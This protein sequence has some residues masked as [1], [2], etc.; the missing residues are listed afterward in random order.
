MAA[1]SGPLVVIFHQSPR[2]G[3]PPFTALLATARDRLVA[4]HTRHFMRAGAARVQVIP[5]RHDRDADAGGFGRR[6]ATLVAEERP[7]HGLIILGSGAVPLL[8]RSDAE[9]LVVAARRGR[10]YA[11]T[12]NRYSSD[13]CAVSQ[14]GAL[15][16][17]L[18]GP[19]MPSDNGLPRWLEADAGYHLQQLPGRRRL[20]MDLDTPLDLALLGL[21]RRAPKALRDLAREL[22]IPGHSALRELASDPRRELLVMGRTNARTLRWLER[23]T[24][25]RVRALI[26]ERGLKASTSGA[27]ARP[28]R[29]VLGRLLT[30]HGPESLA[31]IVG[32][33]S[34]GA[35]IDTRVLLADRLGADEASWPS[36]EDRF[37]SDLGRSDEIHDPWLAALTRSAARAPVPIMLAAHTLVGPGIRVLLGA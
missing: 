3:E 12:N 28:P 17:L 34:D 1:M 15:L 4:H 8:R 16:A 14:P 9:R 24:R 33:L 29:S 21:V 32:E 35:I 5:G 10:R 37:A 7:R 27:N 19:P 18:D 22:P 31:D 6:L 36:P 20:A 2:A 13:V 23:H 30:V 25:C 11:L 26:E